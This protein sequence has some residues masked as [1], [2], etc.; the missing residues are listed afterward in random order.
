MKDLGAVS[1]TLPLPRNHEVRQGEPPPPA[2]K[3]DEWR[4]P[5]DRINN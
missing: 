4:V 2:G 5:A 3:R 1:A